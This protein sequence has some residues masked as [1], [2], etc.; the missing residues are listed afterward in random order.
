M[1]LMATLVSIILLLRKTGLDLL[2]M[3]KFEYNLKSKIAEI[4]HNKI[5]INRITP[6]KVLKKDATYPIDKNSPKTTKI[7]PRSV[8]KGPLKI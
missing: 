2:C 6:Q 1:L 7:L 3:D 5:N 8:F 4:K